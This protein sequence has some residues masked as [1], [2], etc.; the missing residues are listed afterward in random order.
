MMP[1]RKFSVE[2]V[3][4]LLSKGCPL[5]TQDGRCTLDVMASAV[6]RYLNIGS[7]EVCMQMTS[8]SPTF[9]PLLADSSLEDNFIG[10]AACEEVG[11]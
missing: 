11:S 10:D 3:D 9:T 4:S 1:L 2:Q 6:T 7:G 5:C 8:L